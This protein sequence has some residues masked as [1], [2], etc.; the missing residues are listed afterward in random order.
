L[1]KQLLAPRQRL[2]SGALTA[3]V[4]PRQS[5]QAADASSAAAGI[6]GTAAM[7]GGYRPGSTKS[8]P[9]SGSPSRDGTVK[10]APANA[11]RRSVSANRALGGDATARFLHA[12]SPTCSCVTR[13]DCCPALF[14]RRSCG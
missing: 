13:G 12:P 2:V 10:P 8:L 5:T 14:T 7:R 9:A 11:C 4:D 3:A 1:Q 6:W